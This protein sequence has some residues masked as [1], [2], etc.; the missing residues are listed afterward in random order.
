MAHSE[1]IGWSLFRHEDIASVLADPATYSNV[2]GFPAIVNAMDL[3]RQRA[4][5]GA[6]MDVSPV[7]FGCESCY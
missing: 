5:A 6:A 7:Q 4:A 1:F 2:S 3:L